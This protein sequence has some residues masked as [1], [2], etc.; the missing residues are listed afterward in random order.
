MDGVQFAFLNQLLDTF[1]NASVTGMVNLKP[2]ALGLVTVLGILDV[3]AMWGLYFGEMRVRE[4]MGKVIKIG[5][6]VILIL[7]WGPITTAVED[8]FVKVGQIASAH[9]T[10]T[11]PSSIMVEGTKK[12][13]RLWNNAIYDIPMSDTAKSSDNIPYYDSNGNLNKDATKMVEADKK[14]NAPTNPFSGLGESIAAIPGR[15]I[16]IILALAIFIAFAFIALNVLL[17]FVEFYLTTALSIILLPF[18]VNSHTSFISQKALGAVVN[19]GV[20]LMIMI[21]LLGLM[22]TMISKMD[23]ITNDDYG[24][25]FEAVLQ[26]CMY[27]FL[28]WKLPSLISG[29]LSGTPSMGASAAGVVQSA[30]TA[31]G[32]GAMTTRFMGAG[33]AAAFRGM[34]NASRISGDAIR[35]GGVAAAGSNTVRSAI[36]NSMRGTASHLGTVTKGAYRHQIN[37]AKNTFLNAVA[38]ENTASTISRRLSHLNGYKRS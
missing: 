8:T 25:L 14:A 28:I 5:F 1:R 13:Y 37:A 31:A 26:A 2:A 21:F 35:A 30:A 23:A 32:A 22:S 7:N 17:C 11:K 12:M 10:A 16:K 36:Y 20:K 3:T 9:Q 15:I 34:A 38:R 6:F 33:S 18:G 4:I 19:F 24:K 29:M 27:A